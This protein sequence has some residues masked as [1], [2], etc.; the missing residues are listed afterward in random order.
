M[1]ADELILSVLGGLIGLIISLPV[2]V[3]L[4]LKK[5]GYPVR[6]YINKRLHSARKRFIYRAFYYHKSPT[7]AHTRKGRGTTEYIRQL[8]NT[9]GLYQNQQEHA[10][11]NRNKK[12]HTVLSGQGNLFDTEISEGALDLSLIFRDSLTKA[13]SACKDSRYQVAAK[14]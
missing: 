1:T 10:M 8:S 11:S 5:E 6:E 13:L 14:I 7:K 2:V 12:L 3:L 9:V 4:T